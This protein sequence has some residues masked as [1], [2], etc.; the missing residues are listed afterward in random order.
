MNNLEIVVAR[1]PE[2]SWKRKCYWRVYLKNNNKH[3]TNHPFSCRDGLTKYHAIFTANSLREYLG[4][5]IPIWVEHK[6]GG[7]AKRQWKKL[8]PKSNK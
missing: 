5:N 4:G 3:E 2:R 6:S 8:F 1:G 7:M